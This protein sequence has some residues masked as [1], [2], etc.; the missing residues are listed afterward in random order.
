MEL[1]IN[2]TDI[3]WWFWSATLVFIIA[4][5]AGWSPGYYI[6]TAISAIHVLFFWAQERSL[7]AFPVQIRIVYQINS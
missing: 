1:K 7:A 6:V 4:A 2:A 5:V 3:R